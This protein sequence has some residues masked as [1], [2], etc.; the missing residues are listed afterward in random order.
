MEPEALQATL[1]F[2]AV[3]PGNE[4]VGEIVELALDAN[5]FR[6]VH[7]AGG[8]GEKSRPL[9]MADVAELL[10]PFRRRDVDAVL[11][12]IE[13]LRRTLGTS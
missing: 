1:V 13:S 3:S 10:S 12:N 9:T 5:G 8:P 2:R 6:D 7:N 11:A 4:P